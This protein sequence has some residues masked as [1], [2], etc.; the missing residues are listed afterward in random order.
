MREKNH[1][2]KE[3]ISI[4]RKLSEYIDGELDEKAYEEMRTHINECMKCEVC[5]ETLR[6][7]ADLCRGMKT[8]EIPDRLRE[9]LKSMVH[10]PSN[11]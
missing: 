1:D 6:R 5:L 8:R 7:T 9:R 11:P 10:G 3:C 2:H 4:F